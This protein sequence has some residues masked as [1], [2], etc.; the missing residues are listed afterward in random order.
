MNY[1]ADVCIVGA[2]PGG[3]LLSHLLAKKGLSVI[4]LEQNAALGQAFRG[5]HL[6]E[7]GE[8]VLKSH[9]LFE[10]VEA[11]GL[12]RMGKLEYYTEGRAFK[13]I[14]PDKVVGHLGIHV[15]QTNLLK[16]ILQETQ[17]FPH[18]SCF[19]NT[20]VTKLIVDSSGRYT[21]VIA[22]RDGETIEISSQLIIGADGRYSTIRKQAHIDFQKRKHGFDLLWAK[23]PAPQGWEPSIKMALIG[24]KQLSLFTQVG[25]FIQI[26]WNIEQGSFPQLRKKAFTPFIQQLTDQF[27]ELSDT[28]MG[29]IKS[30]QDFVLLDVFSSHS[31][32]W[33]TKGLVLLG[34]AIHTMTPTG[35]FGLNSALKDAECLASLLN[36]NTLAH[37]DVQDFQQIREQDIEEVLAKQIEKEQTFAANFI[38]KAS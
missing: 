22:T 14:L 15:P 34:D 11:L 38:N 4:L 10:A 25:G 7:E 32:S 23:I 5:E 26:G 3:A 31:N 20:K 33:G 12:L 36:K 17:H 16:G 35:A 21:G 9:E 1:Q 13:T 30:W 27:P 6:N 28:V 37:F 19:L 24:D 2:G 8:A 18:F 29:H